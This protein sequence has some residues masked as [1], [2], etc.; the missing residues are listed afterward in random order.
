MLRA[1]LL[2]IMAAGV[3]LAGPPPA[4]EAPLHQAA[5]T[6]Q[7]TSAVLAEGEALFHARW[8]VA[9]SAFGRWGRGPVSN[10]ESC[11]DCHAGAG[12]G[13]VPPSADE[14]VRTA[15]VRLS[16]PGTPAGG[17]PSPHPTYGEQLQHRG[18]LG[19]VPGEGE[20]QVVW[21]ATSVV[22]DDGERVVLRA[23]HL[24]FAQLALGP[25]AREVL[26]SLR[27]APSLHGVGLLEGVPE[28]V[29]EAAAEQQAAYG[30]AGRVNP[31][32]QAGTGARAA[33]RFGL[34]ANQPSLLQQVAAALHQDLGITTPLFPDENC[35]QAQAQCRAF[36]KPAHPELGAAQLAALVA[37]VRQLPAPA[38][39]ATDDPEAERGAASFE[40]SGCARCHAPALRSGHD[41]I[42]PYTDLLVHDLGDGLADGR[43]DFGAGPRDW[44]TAPLWGVGA[45]VRAGAQLLH[46]GRARTLEEAILW[47]GGEAA[48]A[49]AAYR[50]MPRSE[51]D[52]LIAFLRTL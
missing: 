6:A 34:K 43:P 23:P 32:G 21:R 2:S 50:A 20:A 45:A 3:T 36:P 15:L 8:V 30:L 18:V 49:Q 46:D 35:T 19:R 42:Y 39:H 40:R 25:I 37:F 27:V 9:P 13:G 17:A 26:T 12:R 22:L 33:G 38:P 31:V 14:P 51:R 24:R 5:Q 29:L 4:S 1:A 44:R 16:L 28:S 7:S 48:F 52:A 41:V 11:T 10:G 47:H